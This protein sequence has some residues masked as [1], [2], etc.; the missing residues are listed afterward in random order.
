MTNKLSIQ[1]FFFL[2]GGLC[3]YK[4]DFEVAL[5]AVSKKL[6]VILL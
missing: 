5:P 4:Q 6:L 1:V 2:G 3:S